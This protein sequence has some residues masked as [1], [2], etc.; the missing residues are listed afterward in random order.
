MTS[1]KILLIIGLLF[2]SLKV[3]ATTYTVGGLDTTADG[4]TGFGN[5]TPSSALGYTSTSFGGDTLIGNASAVQADGKILVAGAIIEGGVSQVIVARYNINGTNDLSYNGGAIILPIS[6][7]T[8]ATATDIVVAPNGNVL[9]AGTCTISSVSSF[10]I[11]RILSDGFYNGGNAIDTTFGN[12]G[13]IITNVGAIINGTHSTTSSVDTLTA[14]ALDHSGNILVSGTTTITQTGH[15]ITQ[16]IFVARFTPNGTGG[17]GASLGLD[18]TFNSGSAVGGVNYSGVQ[19]V[20]GIGLICST[21]SGPTLIPLVSHAMALDANQKI[22]VVG[23]AT[24]SST[25]ELFVARFTSLGVLDTTFTVNGYAAPTSLAGGSTTGYGVSFQ[26]TG[27]IVVC[28]MTNGGTEAFVARFTTGGLLDPTFGTASS[29]YITSY[30]GGT[31]SI[32]YGIE[33]QLNDTIVVGGQA[34]V[35][36]VAE[37]AIGRFLA[38]GSDLDTSFNSPYG[39]TN[40]L[41]N[42]PSLGFA[43]SIQQNGSFLVSGNVGTII[44]TARYLGDIPQGCMDYTYPATLLGIDV[45]GFVSYPTDSLPGQGPKVI[46][47]Y[48]SADGYLYALIRNAVNVEIVQLA[49]NGSIASSAYPIIVST[50]GQYGNDVI[51]DSSDRAV[52]VGT[53]NP[54]T[55]FGWIGRYTASEFSMMPDPSF[56]GGSIY[57]ES[58]AVSFTRVAQQNND[59]LIAMGQSSLVTTQGIL[60]AY[61]SLGALATG[62]FGTGAPGSGLGYI[63]SATSTSTFCDMVI[64]SSNRIYVAWQ[65]TSAGGHIKIDRYLANG[66]GLDSG[67]AQSGIF[68]TGWSVANYGAPVLSFD[69]YGNI[70]VAAANAS[71]GQIDFQQFSPSCVGSATIATG[72][73]LQSTSLF[74]T[75]VILTKLQCDTDDR[76]VFTGSDSSNNFIGRFNAGLSSGAH[77]LPFTLDTTFA[78]YSS[79]PGILKTVYNSNYNQYDGG[80]PT[81]PVSISNSVCINSYGAIL[82]C[83]YDKIN[84]ASTI[85]FIGQVVGNT[86]GTVYT[87]VPRFGTI[88]PTGTV[89]GTV[90]L[91]TSATLADGHP[92]AMYTFGSGIFNGYT[93]IANQTS[94]TD[95]TLSMVD[96]TY[97]LNTSTGATSF[98][99]SHVGSVALPGLAAATCIMIDTVGDIYVL[100]TTSTNVVVAYKVNSAGTTVSVLTLPTA[101]T[102]AGL[103]SAYGI[104][105]QASGRI[106]ICGYNNEHVGGAS[107]VILAYDP[108]H[109][110]VDSSFNPGNTSGYW[111]TGIANPI[112]AISVGTIASCV[113][114]LYCAYDNYE[115]YAIVARLLENGTAVDSTFNFGTSIICSN[116]SQIKMQLDV[117]G[118]IVLVVQTGGSGGIQAARYNADG[119]NDVAPFTVIPN[120]YGATLKEILCL[121]NGSTLIFGANGTT[122]DLSRLTPLFIA[123]STFNALGST[124]GLLSTTVADQAEFFAVDVLGNNADGIIISSDT[125]AAVTS[126]I[127]YFIQVISDVAVTKVSQSATTLGAAGTLDTTFNAAGTNAGFMNF[128]TSDLSG[129]NGSSRFPTTVSAKVLLQLPNGTNYYVAGST[130]SNTYVTQM[131]DDDIQQAWGNSSPLGMLTITGKANVGGMLYGQNGGL[132]V[133]GGAGSSGSHAGWVL[134][135]S[136]ADGSLNTEF[137]APYGSGSVALDAYYAIAQQSNGRILIA[138]SNGGVGAI[139]ALNSVTGAVDTTFA[140]NGIYTLTS[141]N[142]AIYSMIVGGNDTIY[143]MTTNGSNGYVQ[144]LLANGAGTLVTGSS[145]FTSASAASSNHVAFDRDNNIIAVAA[146]STQVTF[147]RFNGVNISGA[148]LTGPTTFTITGITTPQITSMF[149][150]RNTSPGKVIIAGYDTSTSPNTPFIARIGSDLTGLDITFNNP[151]GVVTTNTVTGGVTTQW[152]A[153]MINADGKITVAGYASVLTDAYMMRVYGDEFIG[154]YLP[155]VAAGVE[156]TIDTNFPALTASSTSTGI[157]SLIGTAAASAIPQVV[158]PAANGAQ[159]VAFASGDTHSASTVA[160]YTNGNVLDTSYHTT[161]IAAASP[162]GLYSMSFLANGGLLVAGTSLF[163]GI[164]WVEQYTT[165]GILDP[166]FNPTGSTVTPYVSATPGILAIPD[167]AVATVAVQQSLSR[168]IVAGQKTSSSH[169]ALFGI[170]NTGAVD[171][172]FGTAGVYDTGILTTI[173]A[174]VADQY[175]RLIIAYKHG[176][177]VEI[178][179]LTSS[180]EV[181]T[182]FGN[183]STGTITTGISTADSQAQVRI[184]LD[185]AGNIVVAAHSS[186]TPAI[187]I[188][189][190]ANTTG[191]N[192]IYGWASGISSLTSPTLTGLIATADGKVLVSGDQ[193]GSNNMWVARITSGGNLD[194]TTFNPNATAGGIVG[195]MQFNAGSAGSFISRQ[196]NSIAI[197]GDGEISMVGTENNGSNNPFM[198]RAYDTPYTTQ[199]P[200]DLMAKAP[201]TVD[202]TFG[203]TTHVLNGI[204]FFAT[205]GDVNTSCNQVA[206]AVVMQNGNDNGVVV[207]LDGLAQSDSSG[208][209][210]YINMF[211]VDGLLNPN[212]NSDA[213]ED[214]IAAGQALVLNQYDN[215]HVNDML[216]FTDINNVSKAI[217]AGFAQNTTPSLTGSLLIQYN[218]SPQA[219]PGL[220]TSFG[221]FNGNPAGVAFGDGHSLK[222]IG[223][224]SNSRI[225]GA[226]LDSL[227]NGLLL[228]Y[229]ATGNLD[230][231]FGQGG[232]FVQT[233]ANGIYTSAI[234]SQDRVVIAYTVDS[235]VTL[236]RILADGSG[237]D[238]T[239]NSPNGFVTTPI[240]TAISNSNLRLAIDGLGNIAVAAVLTSG[241]TFAVARYTSAGV[242][243]TAVNTLGGTMS[244]TNFTITKLLVDAN[245]AVVIVGFDVASSQVVVVARLV[246][247]STQYILDPTFNPTPGTPGYIKYAV[248]NTT[249]RQQT[250]GAFIHPDGR[251]IVGGSQH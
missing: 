216:T 161:G 15:G 167:C 107:G 98:G 133:A 32:A 95:T 85:P 60:A 183:G 13:Y 207:A 77:T 100:G 14:L 7:A 159:Y 79:C 212:F 9:V 101:S 104:V 224:Q 172:T 150:D 16:D 117:N 30:L 152:N 50:D 197:Y 237:L 225:I 81:P 213:V 127:P 131:S 205:S 45:P 246:Y 251:I 71:T 11:I 34:V 88:S 148:A 38:N 109:D 180:G 126:A 186:S 72:S 175:D 31:S 208:S 232:T 200:L 36:T 241:T 196:L 4:G 210:I 187:A 217:I 42:S 184:A 97:A 29:G 102:T 66:S 35:S 93:L 82:F 243:S 54:S 163:D 143:F 21:V 198:S 219:S 86:G 56:N 239:F 62:S 47:I 83:G 166:T 80:T 119:T 39:Y 23:S 3:L 10:F 176:S 46:A 118:K 145:A 140:T 64:D 201:G 40:T 231:S 147:A 96:N 8:Q 37:F 20:P 114:K 68:Y 76:L 137:N 193:S 173:Y 203:V 12:S 115:G 245:G 48:P 74:A 69:N 218:L 135:Y 146:T 220:D 222:T 154:Q 120:S 177:A 235:T 19:T 105:Q 182:T 171:A 112:T 170:T 162:A 158:L 44:G 121:S 206:R 73:I 134:E 229:T 91:G 190:Y 155:T 160:R 128:T 110:Q 199:Q 67:F 247:S 240:T 234:D 65:D 230:Q 27:K 138:G 78:P 149:V 59:Q 211:D 55:G 103:T 25:P 178:R 188:W 123:D 130:G 22:V 87:Q 204:T 5:A 249:D 122:L 18:T 151:T 164:G 106:L 28:G 24:I 209:S 26:S 242:L 179:R 61:T 185:Q 41:I 238:T 94:A 157:L 226:G 250:V 181:D 2:S 84:N 236:A 63:V 192:T 132:Y 248:Y 141:G 174:M 233:S 153:G 189:A 108:V 33:I 156:G 111:Y 221:G 125:N 75:P 139:I 223:L 244:L 168:I 17:S 195:V 144:Q 113:D 129:S 142:G 202:N 191:T 51:T 215:Q 58:H 6:G 228:G 49:S 90:N 136:A 57:E 227:G 1:R 165:A 116:V 70:V 99:V 53:T 43:L 194:T 89:G 52:V 124:T 214:Y 169:G 92:R